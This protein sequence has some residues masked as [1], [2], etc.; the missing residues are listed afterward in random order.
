MNIF[1][2]R[3]IIQPTKGRDGR[4]A[5]GCTQAQNEPVCFVQP[6]SAWSEGWWESGGQGEGGQ[7]QAPCLE[8]GKCLLHHH[9]QA[10]LRLKGE[11]L[12]LGNFQA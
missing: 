2:V 3:T 7:V 4:W 9:Y 1:G 11:I 6:P 8:N 5:D 10:E 12:S